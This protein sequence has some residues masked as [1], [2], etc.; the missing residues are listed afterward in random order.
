MYA[1]NRNPAWNSFFERLPSLIDRSVPTALTGDSNTVFDR[2]TDRRGCV[3]SDVSRESTAALTDLLEACC[4]I[5]IWQYLHPND[6]AFTWTRS[7][8]LLGSR[9]DLIGAPFLW[10]P[11]VSS[12]DIFPCPFSDHCCVSLSVHVPD[13]VPP[14]P[15]LWK[16]NRSIL[17]EDAYISLITNFWEDWHYRLSGF[18]SLAK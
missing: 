7:D 5:D 9:I 13:V 12:C 6:S 16:L 15:G 8:G 1:P 17:H 18:S 10:V 14:G 2:A 3:A 4:C 11:S